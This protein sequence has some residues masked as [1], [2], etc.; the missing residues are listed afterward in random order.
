VTNTL[1]QSVIDLK[2]ENEKLSKAIFSRIG[3]AKAEALLQEKISAPADKFIRELKKPGNL[4]VDNA[5]RS[6]LNDL[7]KKT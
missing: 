5:T 3:K 6:F 4:I 2:L 7:V 1:E